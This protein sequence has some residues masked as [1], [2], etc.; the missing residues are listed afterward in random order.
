MWSFI[1]GELLFRVLI[2]G[3]TSMVGIITI[4]GLLIEDTCEL[5][6]DVF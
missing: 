1:V 3:I 5:C 4:F 6:H 2:M